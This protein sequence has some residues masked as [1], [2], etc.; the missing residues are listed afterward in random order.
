MYYINEN[1]LNLNRIF[2][3]NSREGYLR[4][5][6]NENPVGLPLD[7]IKKVLSDVDQEFI[8][9]YPETEEFQQFLADFIN[10][11]P[12]QICLTNG[13]AEAI[14][15]IFEVYSR[16]N[17]KIVSVAPSYAMYEV[18]ANMYGRQHVGVPYDENFKIS[19]DKIVDAIDDETDIVVILNPNNP[20]GDVYSYEDAEKIIL[21]AQAHEATVL[22]DEAYFYFYPNTF[23]SFV[24]KYEHV[25]LTRTFSKLFSLAGCRLG[26]CVGRPEDIALVQKMCTPHNVNAFG[27]KFAHTIMKTEGMLDELI[28]M[29]IEGK[30]HL[31]DTLRA[32]GYNVNAL[33]GNFVF[34]E[35]KTDAGEVT[36]KLKEN[37]VLVKYYA[38]SDYDKYIRVSTGTKEIMDEFIKN[39][40]SV[41][42]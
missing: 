5:D 2:D 4:F 1:T 11:N 39:L 6:L 30:Q 3:Q 16:P 13:S 19:V 37:K 12:N 18:Y 8:A 17:G 40:L 32:E 9:K 21:A 42:K 28:K 20:V 33:E 35:T 14:R 24:D 38:N 23:M 7:F 29:Q 36:K 41:D 34:I 15:H 10:V 31:V 27:I 26:Y 22:I 25:I